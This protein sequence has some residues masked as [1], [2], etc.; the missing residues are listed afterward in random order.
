MNEEKGKPVKSIFEAKITECDK[1]LDIKTIGKDV[2]N[3]F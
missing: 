1:H 3:D 2:Q